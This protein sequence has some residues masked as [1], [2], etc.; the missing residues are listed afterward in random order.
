MN[1]YKSESN[2]LEQ[3]KEFINNKSNIFDSQNTVGHITASGFIYSKEDESILLLS[4]KKLNRYLQPGGHVELSD[5]NLLETVLREIKE[6]TQLTNL[7]L[8][9]IFSDKNVPFDINIHILFQKT[10][11]RICLH[12][13]IMISDTYLLLIK[14]QIYISI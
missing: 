2:N 5:N 11:K 6:E 1:Y 3:F 13:I 12:T 4:H 9:N 8:V 14:C 7:E 10:L